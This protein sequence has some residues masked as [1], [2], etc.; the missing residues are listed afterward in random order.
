MKALVEVLLRYRAMMLL[1]MA[2][3][4]SVCISSCGWISRPTRTLRRH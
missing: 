2:G 1:A 3:W 4:L